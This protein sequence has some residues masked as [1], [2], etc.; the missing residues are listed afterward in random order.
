[1]A[2]IH[3]TQHPTTSI[4]HIH[5]TH[6]YIHPSH[7]FHPIRG[8]R[9]DEGHLRGASCDERHLRGARCDKGHLRGARC[10]EEHL[11]GAR[12]DEGHLRGARCDEGHLRGARCDKVLL[13]AFGRLCDILGASG[14]LKLQECVC[15]VLGIARLTQLFVRRAFLSAIFKF[16]IAVLALNVHSGLTSLFQVIV[17]IKD[18][19]HS[20][21]RYKMNGLQVK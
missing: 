19:L 1:M 18:K 14:L 3:P 17:T 21:K 16:G 8:A 2:H 15:H 4:E 7:A 20:F 12:C 6:P 9:C 13:V 10:D 11:R 5:T